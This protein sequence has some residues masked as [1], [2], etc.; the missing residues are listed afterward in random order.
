MK[1]TY[2]QEGLFP[3]KL[4]VKRGSLLLGRIL[5]NDMSTAYYFMD[6][7]GEATSVGTLDEIKTL[8]ET[9]LCHSQNHL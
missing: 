7:R 2:T 9:S 1:I 8:V 5:A 3:F 4:R 6:R